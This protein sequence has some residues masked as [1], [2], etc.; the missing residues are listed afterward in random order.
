MRKL[1]DVSVVLFSHERCLD[2]DPGY[3]HPERPDR[4]RA[5]LA[6]LDAAEFGSD[7]VRVVAP[8]AP[9]EA[10]GAVHPESLIAAIGD[11]ATGGGGR[12]DADTVV[13][14]ASFDAARLAAG[15]GLAAIDELTAG[16]HDAALCL[17]R[18]PGHHA[19]AA[20]SMG[21]CL[22]NSAA[23]SAM[24]LADR[25]ERVL[26]VDYDAHH[27]NGTESIFYRDPRVLF[28]SLHQMPLYPGT[29]AAYDRGEG[30]GLGFTLNVPVP[31]R[32]TG[33][34]YQRAFDDVI[35][36]RVDSFAPTW[37]IL[38]AGFDGHRADPITELGL[39][40]GDF[41]ALT[42][43]L[44]PLVPPGRCIAFLEGG[45]DLDALA[46]CTAAVTAELL[47]SPIAAEAQTSGGPGVGHVD[48]VAALWAADD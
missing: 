8:L 33:D 31:A 3:G 24:A 43:R 2:H 10:I 22:F 5:A 26:I 37:L 34:V 44:V 32:T 20:Q 46:S 18:P 14:E 13:S 27:G 19:T 12:I 47:G 7:V 38:S 48:E 39:T 9:L 40:S 4:L 28:V 25:G 15:A 6:G 23:V 21:F 1:D 36:A 17:V 45:Y 11:L 41:A 29:G 35:A 42:R 16:P 30:P